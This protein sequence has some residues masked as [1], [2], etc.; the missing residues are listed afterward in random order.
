MGRE[1]PAITISRQDR[2]EYRA[3]VR[4]CLDGPVRMLH[5]SR[6]ETDYQQV[7]LEI[8]F[9]LVDKVGYPAINSGDALAA[10][11]DQAWDPELGK[12]NI[13][14]AADPEIL[15]DG[16][17]TALEAAIG[18][19]VKRASERIEPAGTRLVMIGILPSVRE[20]DVGEG[21]LSASPRFKLLNDQILSARGEEM[22]I[23]IDG[24]DR[25]LTYLDTIMAEAPCT[26]LQ[27]H[28]PVIPETFASYWNAAQAV[29]AVQLA[30][31][32]NSPFLLAHAL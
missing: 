5:E 17:F 20:T 19:I 27:C 6:F 15:T 10:S 30:I 31:S 11:D 24:Q 9:H 32:A 8:E 14:L 26:R 3:K 18:G 2:R 4:S 23:C 29:A 12:F 13:E 21:S 16:V 22:R 1:V 7:G 25:V 28:L